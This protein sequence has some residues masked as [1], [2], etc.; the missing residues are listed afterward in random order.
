[1]VTPY[2]LIHKLLMPFKKEIGWRPTMPNPNFFKRE[3]LEGVNNIVR[4]VSITIEHKVISRYKSY[5]FPFL[6]VFEHPLNSTEVSKIHS[7][8]SSEHKVIKSDYGNPYRCRISDM[9]FGSKT[10][11]GT[12]SAERQ[13]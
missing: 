3:M 11:S 10:C 4:I 2:F 5:H 1:M 13:Y 7:F 8:L 12:G 6:I 9:R